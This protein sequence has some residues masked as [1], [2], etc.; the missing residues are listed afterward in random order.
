MTIINL[1][2]TNTMTGQQYF[3]N[4]Q[5]SNWTQFY[6]RLGVLMGQLAV[7]EDVSPA[8]ISHTITNQAVLMAA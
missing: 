2:L 8:N 1:E 7:I 6:S 4:I 5:I 3:Y